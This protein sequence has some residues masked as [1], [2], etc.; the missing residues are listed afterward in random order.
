MAGTMAPMEGA[1]WA[2][3]YFLPLTMWPTGM[4]IATVWVSWLLMGC[5]HKEWFLPPPTSPR[6][7]SP[8]PASHPTHP[9]ISILMAERDGKNTLKFSHQ[10]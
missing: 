2:V 10:R 4:L 1:S 3:V 8:H 5:R 6:P 9:S 7:T